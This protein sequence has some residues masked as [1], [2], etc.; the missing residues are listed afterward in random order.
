VRLWDVR[1]GAARLTLTE[2][3]VQEGPV[4]EAIT[5]L[6]FAP[7]GRHLLTGSRHGQLTR[8][9]TVTGEGEPLPRRRGWAHAVAVSPDGALLAVADAVTGISG[10]DLPGCAVRPFVPPTQ[11]DNPAGAR[12][13]AFSPDGRTLSAGYWDGS[14]RLWDVARCAERPG[15]RGPHTQ[16]HSLSFS[17]DGRTLAVGLRREVTMR[18]WG[19][20]HPVL[21]WDTARAAVR[22]AV[23]GGQPTLAAAL[24]PDGHWLLTGDEGRRLRVWDTATGEE[25]LAVL[26]HRG[27]VSAVTLSPDGRTVASCGQ[28]GTVRLWPWEALWPEAPSVT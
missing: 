10:W 9:D 27:M 8:W 6:A 22:R 24:T 4:T 2:A 21:L 16:V 28:D 19:P 1:T 23:A 13:L 12:R 25:S 17:A 18:G 3:P 14:V 15:L 7:D 26:W 5:C 11:G 20:P